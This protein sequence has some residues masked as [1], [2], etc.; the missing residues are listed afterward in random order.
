V[1]WLAALAIALTARRYTEARREVVA[2]LRCFGLSRRR[3]LLQLGA[4]LGIYGLP[5]IGLGILAG[6][7]SAGS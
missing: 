3:I 7:W 6:L 1:L 2:Q 4:T 5:A